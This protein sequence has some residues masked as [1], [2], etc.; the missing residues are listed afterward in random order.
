MNIKKNVNLKKYNTFKISAQTK[1]FCKISGLADL[2]K[3]VCNEIYLNNKHFILG[4]GSNVL[5]TKDFD[6]LIIYPVFKGIKILA[7]EKNFVIIE[8]KSGE[9]W[10]DLVRLCV[11]N[12]WWGIENLAAI[13]GKVGA[14]PVQNIGAYGSEAKDVIT[15]VKYFNL[16]T[17]QLLTI[18]NKDCKFDYRDSIF[19]NELKDKALIYAVRFKLSK[20]PCFEI[21]HPE[22]KREILE[23]QELNLYTKWRSVKAVRINK[24][25]NL[26]K[27]PNAGSF[28]KNPIVEIS[29]YQDLKLRYPELISYKV[30]DNY[31]KIPAAQLIE[32]ANMKALKIGEV[33]TYKKHALIIVNYGNAKGAEILNFANKIIAEVKKM[34]DIQ[35]IQ[36]VNII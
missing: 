6:G 21:S 13:P 23:Y 14:A 29:K 16:Q 15:E 28:F 27:F 12:N 18:D 5:F 33:G 24:L 36:E 20:I 32:L 1:Y 8:V 9:K 35:L 26:K 17:S 31:C 19:K 34:F 10:K 2:K 3:L 30:S 22:I 7:E 4:E 11:Q 25:P